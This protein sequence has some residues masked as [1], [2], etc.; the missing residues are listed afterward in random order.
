[1]ASIRGIRAWRAI[2][3]GACLTCAVTYPVVPGAQARSG[4][5]VHGSVTAS[6]QPLPGVVVTLRD[7]QGR[8]LDVSSSGADGSFVINAPSS[9]SFT[10]SALLVAFAPISRDITIDETSCAQRV[11]LTLTLASRAPQTTPTGGREAVRPPLAARGVSG[12]GPA[13]A[14]AGRQPFQSLALVAD[15][16]GA[17]AEPETATGTAEALLPPGFSIET[18]ADSVTAFGNTLHVT[19]DDPAALEAAIA[20]VRSMPGLTWQR[21]EA[22]LEDVFIDLMRDAQDNR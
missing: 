5:A 8:T 21:A 18:S 17:R 15:P 9:G 11:D 14:A 13:A 7:G 3:Y 12:R 19:G 4:C 20:P 10:L 22:G 6:R 1:M 16:S 2:A